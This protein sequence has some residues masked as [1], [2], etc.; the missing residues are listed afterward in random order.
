LRSAIPVIPKAYRLIC[1]SVNGPPGRGSHWRVSSS[2]ISGANHRVI[3]K[4]KDHNQLNHQLTKRDISVNSTILYLGRILFGGYFL[5]NAMNH[6]SKLPAMTGY[7]QSKGIPAA[8]L[9]VAGGGILLAV[10]GT[11]I[12]FNIFPVA[13]LAS[14]ALFLV[15][16][17]FVM[18]AFWKVQDPMARMGEKVNFTKNLALLGAVAILLASHF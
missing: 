2:R 8:K 18:H 6:F 17:T 13:G 11:S 7:A 5:F 3:F 10:G 4:Q 1:G 16:V 15:P 12:L 9:A 14:L